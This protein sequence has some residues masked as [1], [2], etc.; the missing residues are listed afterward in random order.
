MVVVI[1]SK[2]TSS[3]PDLV[4]L[5]RDP[6]LQGDNGGVTFMFDL[7]F[8]YCWPGDDPA[9]GAVIQDVAEVGDGAFVETGDGTVF[10]GG[11]FDFTAPITNRAYV[12][13]PAGCLASIHSGPQHFLAVGWY[14]LPAS[15]NWFATPGTTAPIFQCAATS[16]ASGPELVA[17]LQT[18]VPRLD[19]RRQTNGSTYQGGNLDPNANVY[20]EVTQIAYWRNGAGVGARMRS[21]LGVINYTTVVGSDNVGDFSAMKPKWGVPPGFAA[22]PNTRLY[23]GWIEDLA[24]SGRDPINVLDDDFARAIARGAF[25]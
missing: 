13:G 5:R 20:G 7:A 15:G 22:S 16:Y 6:I 2:V 19:I 24:V 3:A 14:K 17:W 4:K 23:R 25:S 11:G 12:E 10:A 21:S 8:G 18:K 1:K 9:G